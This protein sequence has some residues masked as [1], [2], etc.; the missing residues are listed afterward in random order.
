MYVLMFVTSYKGTS[1]L[2]QLVDHVLE[3]CSSLVKDWLLIELKFGCTFGCS[4]VV[5]LGYNMVDSGIMIGIAL[6]NCIRSSTPLAL[7]TFGVVTWV[8]MFCNLKSYQSIQL[9]T[10]NPYRAT[11]LLFMM[12]PMQS[13]NQLEQIKTIKHP[14]KGISKSGL[15]NPRRGEAEEGNIGMRLQRDA[16]TAASGRYRHRWESASAG[17][18]FS[19]REGGR[20]RSPLG[21]FN[22]VRMRQL[23]DV[24]RSVEM[25]VVDDMKRNNQEW[26]DKNSVR[27]DLKKLALTDDMTFVKCDFRMADIRVIY[28][29]D[30]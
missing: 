11:H 18:G 26:S 5:Q 13:A 25:I 23:N 29:V 8:H 2:F 6:A 19:G 15:M 9:T 28:N 10:L 22:N 20:H 7:A 1:G 21:C 16:N 24:V 27:L 4:F 3:C 17:C 12:S 30:S 14:F